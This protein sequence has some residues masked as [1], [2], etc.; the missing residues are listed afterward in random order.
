MDDS[1]P[2]LAGRGLGDLCLRNGRF[3]PLDVVAASVSRRNAFVPIVAPL[4]DERADLP[5][6]SRYGTRYARLGQ[7]DSDPGAMEVPF[8]CNGKDGA[9][10]VQMERM[11]ATHNESP[12]QIISQGS[13]TLPNASRIYTEKL[14]FPQFCRDRNLLSSLIL[15]AHFVLA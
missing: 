15:P 2:C 11:M 14:P 5:L 3:D 6:D 1:I 7:A 8:F 13:P 10:I 9:E 12:Q 4:E